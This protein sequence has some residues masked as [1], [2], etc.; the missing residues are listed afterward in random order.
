MRRNGP[1]ITA[2]TA[3]RTSLSRIKLIATVLLLSS[4]T[5]LRQHY[6]A[7]A[8]LFFVGTGWSDNCR[9]IADYESDG[10]RDENPMSR[11]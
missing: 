6:V 2:T 11:V 9:T 10:S 8:S 7:S 4:R 1:T 5:F 3:N